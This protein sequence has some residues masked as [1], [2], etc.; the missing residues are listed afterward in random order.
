MKTVLILVGT[1]PEAIK[2]A[3]LA[4]AIEKSLT[5]RAEV[6]LTGQHPV[7]ASN[8][9]RHF[10]V[11]PAR[12]LPIQRKTSSLS[13]LLG[14][15]SSSLAVE[16][17]K[18][19]PD[20]ILVQGDTTSAMIGAMA[21]FYEGIPVFHV[22][23]G[24]RSYDLQQP[25]PEEFNRRVISLATCLHFC[26]TA[27]SKKQLLAEGVPARSIY[28][29]GNTCIDA[30][31][32]TLAKKLPKGSIFSAGKRGILVTG[33]RRENW[34]SGLE[35]MCHA[36]RQVAVKHSDVEIVYAVHP[37]PLVQEI[38]ATVLQG[39]PGVRL[40]EPLSYPDFC[41]AMREACLIVS[42][43]GGVQEEALALGTPVLVTRNVTE[44]PEVLKWSTVRLVG[45]NPKR[46]VREV[47]SLLNNPAAYRKAATPHFPFGRGD[48]A[49]K[50]TAV[51]ERFFK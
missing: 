3:P 1:R 7:L 35:Q 16:L 43:S 30:L 38:A 10:C 45:N 13:E 26:P 50:I 12:T 44:R 20:G 47:D 28:V 17:L 48:A 4:R 41:M 51:I 33:H 11:R 39:I 2:V 46:I 8:M 14:T 23:A 29:A 40:I 27:L 15:T 22:E 42:D 6:I 32:W 24:L 18:H 31:M 19:R 36:L 9:L 49:R 37:N 25:F 34:E 21:G 5:L